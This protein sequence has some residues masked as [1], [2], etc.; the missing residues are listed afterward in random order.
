MLCC[1]RG[2]AGIPA[3]QWAVGSPTPT[4]P[5]TPGESVTSVDPRESG[6]TGKQEGSGLARLDRV[7]SPPINL[8]MLWQTTLYFIFAPRGNREPV[9]TCDQ[10][11]NLRMGLVEQPDCL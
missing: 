7:G 10:I 6:L 3:G 9:F 11:H 8:R 5:A 4:M 2:G 1:L